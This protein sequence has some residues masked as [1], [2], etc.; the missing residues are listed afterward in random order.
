MTSRFL[1]A[2]AFLYMS[3][4]AHAQSSGATLFLGEPYSYDG[5]LAGTGHAAIYLDRICA[6]TPV[7]LRPC[8]PDETGVVLSRYSG[9][10]GYD[11]VAI[12][13]IPYLYAV[14]RQEDIP[15]FADKKLLSFLR[16]SYRR[17][18]LEWM[19]PD[20]PGG[21]KPDGDWYELAGASY[22][23]TIY[24]YRF[25]TDPKKDLQLIQLLNDRPN[26]KKWRL[27]TANC[28]D[29]VREIIDF[30]YPHAVHRSIIGDLGVTT[31][32]QVAKTLSKYARHHPELKMSRFV[33]P[34]VPGTIPRS[35]PV[36][37]V[38][39]C[40]LTAKKYM[41]P[42][43]ALH[44]YIMGTLVAGYI[45]HP[46]FDP[47][48]DAPILDSQDQLAP[49]L[50]HADRHEFQERMNG[51]IRAESSENV[52]TENWS[53]WR[54]SAKPTLDTYGKPVLRVRTGTEFRDV[55]LARV[56]ILRAQDGTELAASLLR[57]RL[58]EELDSASR[59]TARTDVERDL[60]L[61][62]Q[63]LAIESQQRSA[64]AAAHAAEDSLQSAMGIE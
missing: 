53:S 14:E 36:H 41:I 21:G 34:Q 42:L 60:D 38:L 47:S 50:T 46:R 54:A 23:R 64:S 55:G 51:M 2:V 39:E 32:K 26:H 6:E 9:V 13:L 44:P 1:A 7:K 33:I 56:N 10:A 25:E 43:F 48:K 18:N 5:A 28:A 37:G 24:A 27:V 4:T 29:F 49:A 31:P 61:L 59:K 40:A 12:P 22:I 63:L 3:M 11:W 30:Y 52:A 58:R 17:D 16:D 8:R 45:G 35:K 57:A 62:Q 19:I 15:L 20:L